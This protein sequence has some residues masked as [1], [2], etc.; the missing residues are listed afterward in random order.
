MRLPLLRSTHPL[1]VL[2]AG[3]AFGLKSQRRRAVTGKEELVG[4]TGVARSDLAP[5]GMVFL[6]GELWTAER[7][8]DEAVATG[9][10]VLVDRVDGLRL[11]VRKAPENG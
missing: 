2:A 10:R 8:G 3:L 1:T 5:S 9:D 6:E 4:R 7:V 11:V